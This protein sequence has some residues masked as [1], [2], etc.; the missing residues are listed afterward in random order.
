MCLIFG[1]LLFFNFTYNWLTTS[2]CDKTI[3]K[4][5]VIRHVE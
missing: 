5:A 4:F 1:A 3:E 2:L